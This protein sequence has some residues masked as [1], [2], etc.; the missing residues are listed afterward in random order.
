V[1]QF[2]TRSVKEREQIDLTNYSFEEFISFLFAREAPLELRDNDQGRVGDWWFTRVEDTF[3]PEIICGYYVQLFRK[4]EFLRQQFSKPQL[5]DGFWAIQSANLNCGLPNLLSDTNLAFEKRE[6]CIRAMAD[7]FTSLF[8]DE[9]LDTSV[10][11]WWDSLCYDWHSGNRSRDRGGED[12]QLQDVFFQTLA[13]ILSVA[14]KTCQNAA[15]HGLGHLHHPDTPALID[16]YL[17]EH[18]SLTADSK[19]YALA[20]AKFAV[21]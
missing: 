4:P 6:N 16:R 11:M 15:L 9:A 1:T 5:E 14:S 10:H 3:E 13:Q 2:Y 20:A 19:A 17:R 7:L 21:L 12:E 18:P 8:L